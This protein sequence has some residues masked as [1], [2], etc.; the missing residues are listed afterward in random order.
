MQNAGLLAALREVPDVAVQRRYDGCPILSPNL[1]SSHLR[2][3]CIHRW[4]CSGGPY[5]TSVFRLV[6]GDEFGGRGVQ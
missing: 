1:R 4:D 5:G 6:S 3:V 2:N